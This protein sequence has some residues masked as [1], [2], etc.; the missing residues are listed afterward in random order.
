MGVDCAVIEVDGGMV[1]CNDDKVTGRGYI[2]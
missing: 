1:D 2:L